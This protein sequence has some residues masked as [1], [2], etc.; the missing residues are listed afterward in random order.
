MKGDERKKQQKH[1]KMEN[2]FTYNN[3]FFFFIIGDF[4]F[5]RF[6]LGNPLGIR[7]SVGIIGFGCVI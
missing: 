7:S 2:N 3:F 6:D 1:T 4:I 5:R